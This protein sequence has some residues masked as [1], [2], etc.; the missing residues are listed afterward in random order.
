[1]KKRLLTLMG[2]LLIA[3]TAS[4]N[5]YAE[6]TSPQQA[7]QATAETEDNYTITG[8]HGHG[9]WTIYK[10]DDPSTGRKKGL[11][12]I[13]ITGG[14]QSLC[15]YDLYRNLT[16]APWGCYADEVSSV[17]VYSTNKSIWRFGE[18]AFCGIPIAEFGE[19]RSGEHSGF[20][21]VEELGFGCFE[22][23]K[24][25]DQATFP[26]VKNVSGMAFA[27]VF[28]TVVSLPSV[29]TVGED[30]FDGVGQSIM[31]GRQY[32]SI[33]YID[34]GENVTTIK[35][36]AF[37]T[38]SLWKYDESPSIF[39][40]SPTPPEWS[41]LYE[42]SGWDIFF[43]LD[44]EY[45]YP[46]G[47]KPGTLHAKYETFLGDYR[48]SSLNES[49]ENCEVIVVVPEAYWLTYC[50]FYHQNHPE[51]DYGYMCAYYKNGDHKKNGE[52]ASC[53]R[54][55]RG[56]PI[57]EDNNMIGWYYIDDTKHLH[58][59]TTDP[60]YTL[61]AYTASNAPW[62]AFLGQASRVILHM[63]KIAD[64]AFS[65]GALD[66]ID[67][68]YIAADSLE[69]G[70]SAFSGNTSLK[71]MET[72]WGAGEI[73]VKIGEKA[74]YNCS[75]LSAL[76]RN[77]KT[78]SLGESA[79]ENCAKLMQPS[80]IEAKDI[81]V[82]AFKG[83]KMLQTGYI[84]FGVMEKIDDQ[85]FEGCNSGYFKQ[86][87]FGKNLKS[88]GTKAFKGCSSLYDIYVE[89]AK[90][91]TTASDAFS[92]VTLS[93]ITLHANGSTYADYGKHAIWGQ[94]KVDKNKVLPVGGPGQG[95]SISSD[96]TL[97]V[98]KMTG[99][100]SSCTEQPWYSYR[101]FIN[102]II[103]DNGL[104]F[105]SE[106]EFSFP[107]AGESHVTS[108]S[109]PRS[110]KSIRANAFRNNDQLKTIYISSVE[111]IG[112]RAFYGCSELEVIELGENL[113]QA[114][115][116]V[117]QGCV[118]LEKV[119]DYTL[120]AATVGDDFLTGIR[121]ALTAAPARAPQQQQVN[122]NMPT[123]YVQDAAL[124]NYLVANGW[125]DFNFGNTTEHG[126]IVDNG[127]FGNGHYILWS[128]GTLVCS[129]NEGSNV[130]LSGSQR[131]LWKNSVKRIEVIG[132]LTELK[133]YFDDLPNLEFV[134][135][136]GSIKK[137]DA[138]TFTNCTKLESI[139]LDN[140]ESVGFKC[141]S[142][143]TGLTKAIMPRL[144]EIGQN[145]FENTSS[146]E[147][148]QAGEGC[149]INYQAFKN[150]AVRAIDLAGSD[151]ANANA[152][153][154]GCNNLKYVAYNGAVVAAGTFKNCT[155]LKTVYLGENVE[156][157]LSKAF[158]GCTALDSIYSSCPTPPVVAE[159]DEV[160]KNLTLSEIHLIV[161]EAYE[162][163]Y[164][165]APVWKDMNIGY[166]K[167][168][169]YADMSYPIYIPLGGGKGMAIIYDY[170]DGKPMTIDY[171]GPLPA[172]AHKL[173]DR[174][175]PLNERAIVISDNVTEIP[176]ASSTTNMTTHV[177]ASE[178]L[179]IGANVKSI[180]G[181]ALYNDFWNGD[182]FYI[183]CYAPVPPTLVGTSFNMD[184]MDEKVGDY[185]IKEREKVNLYIIDDDAVYD[186]YIHAPYYHYFNIVRGL[187]P[188]GAPELVTVTFVDW[189][190][191]II[192]QETVEWGG[193]V[194]FPADPVRQGYV[195]KGWSEYS[196]N[197][198]QADMT[199]RAE[200]YENMY[201]VRFFDWDNT[202]LKEEQVLHGHSATAPEDPI[203]EGYMFTGWGA[204]W[205]DVTCDLDLYASYIKEV[206]EGIEDVEADRIISSKFIHSGQM[207]IRRGNAIYTIQ[208]QRVK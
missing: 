109:I 185:G 37:N 100:Y 83:C 2:G 207:Y 93:N 152:A 29:V 4:V 10:T 44:R 45:E 135:L 94:M 190:D 74:F 20:A 113:K 121:T 27:G 8:T 131:T 38:S 117:F 84:N 164:W 174:Y 151:L 26:S 3:A 18:R 206:A 86:M 81:P 79:F 141:F 193:H 7:P 169:A 147:V 34:L 48:A 148:V 53:G 118:K 41:R 57:Y 173:I 14:N 65:N 31:S 194:A 199:V 75:A 90:V 144:K 195:F 181:F 137:L 6:D 157:V 111:N 101:E 54:I 21:E 43:G 146:L 125:K 192:A 36:G 51:V 22:Q 87:K 170:N 1:M 186:R 110:C 191:R 189:D 124:C 139:V 82:K 162:R 208:G 196:L 167:R 204:G 142:G 33:E 67:Y 197:N 91:P 71:Y 97:V 72:Y 172:E 108:V 15:N 66:G 145:A 200:Y 130:T 88:I 155:A 95:W 178:Y 46:F 171:E 158:E 176:A 205:F 119:Y 16:T 23:G 132:D 73:P 77:L 203:R 188:S 104:T 160:F 99:N 177:T 28:G 25:P 116:Y 40:Q 150:S 175:M 9:N 68:I 184:L 12:E 129:S 133:G 70:N 159:A 187:A 168:P 85:A 143:C 179:Q 154:D 96:G 47:D 35:A 61:P 123:L 103:I 92:G 165:D 13:S 24:L 180:G 153:F 105:I 140:V 163:P 64:N 114:G 156:A 107:T 89:S 98:Y 138:G 55:V 122:P 5:L 52:Y 39:I 17:Y 11:L 202:L 78:I 182:N 58:I 201:T 166:D 80:S 128:D 56:G 106:N 198:I 30:A 120:Q 126:T 32:S 161:P 63:N 49:S 60:S 134:S 115:N 42:R 69:I 50:G 19:S 59:G 112:D 127:V 76:S 102:N 136:S 183:D 149:V 62:R